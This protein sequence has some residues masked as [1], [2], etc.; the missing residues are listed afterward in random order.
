VIEFAA[1]ADAVRPITATGASAGTNA[2]EE[3]S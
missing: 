2:A 3:T 1:Y